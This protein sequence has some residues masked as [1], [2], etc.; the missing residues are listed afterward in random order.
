MNRKIIF[1]MFI[2]VL[3]LNA[4]KQD[5]NEADNKSDPVVKV[6]NSYLYA[7]DISKIVPPNS[8][9]EDS[10]NIVQSYINNWIQDQLMLNKAEEYLKEQKAD[11]DK[12]T[13]DFR[14]SLMIH[15]FKE[16]IIKNNVDSNMSSDKIS[17]YYETHKQ[18]LK[19]NSSIIKGFLVKLPK[20][21]SNFADFKIVI[22]SSDNSDLD[23]IVSFVKLKNGVFEDFTTTWSN[24]SEQMLKMP[25]AVEDEKTFLKRSSTFESEDTNFFYYMHVNDYILSG[26]EAPLE[27]VRNNIANILI[28]LESSAIL[29]AYK[30]D[31]YDEAVKTGKIEY[32]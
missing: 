5:K 31:I 13:E 22:N 10:M 1:L 12:K 9:P 28:Q 11:I 23:E 27:F 24:F 32:Y 17:N 14:N 29:E 2:L 6:F 16:T 18:E 8:N 30:Q 15:K 3:L 7:D 21:T 19:L 20:S 4:C 25:I 26:E